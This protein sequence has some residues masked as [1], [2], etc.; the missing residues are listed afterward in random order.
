LCGIDLR[1]LQPEASQVESLCC[2]C[3][4]QSPPSV[5]TTSAWWQPEADWHRCR[6]L[7]SLGHSGLHSPL[8]N[9]LWLKRCLCSK[10][11][12]IHFLFLQ[13]WSL[14]LS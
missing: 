1:A 6:P 8:S 12:W 7:P 13:M 14:L 9:Q 5:T 4:M 10:M 2:T 3:Q 11:I